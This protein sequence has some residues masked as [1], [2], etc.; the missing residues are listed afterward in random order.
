MSPPWFVIARAGF[1]ST[2]FQAAAS[3]ADDVA[4]AEV[5]TAEAMAKKVLARLKR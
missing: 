5:A 2:A 1:L 4:V 3:G